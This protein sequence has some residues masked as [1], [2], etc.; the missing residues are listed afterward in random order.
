MKNTIFTYCNFQVDPRIAENQAKVIDKMRYG[1]GIDF[2]PLTYHLKDGDWFPDQCIDYGLNVLFFERG[3]DNV[4]I[5]DIDCIPLSKY[6]LLYSFYKA[7]GGHLIGDVQRSLHL[8][9][10]EHLF[11]GSSCLCINKEVYNQIGRPSAACTNR[12]DICEEFSYIFE[13]TNRPIELYVPQSFEAAPYERPS[14]PLS[15]DLKHYGIGT[16]F[17]HRETHEPM[18]Y[19]LF[20]SRL[21]QN[22]ELFVK[23]CEAVLQE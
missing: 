7:M 2:N 12:G 18:F 14:W 9:N 20:E 3:Y 6:A 1:T 16:T 4:L 21:N 8:Q 5:L 17:E 15:G 19:H 22:V 23:K 10:N 13:E 11:V